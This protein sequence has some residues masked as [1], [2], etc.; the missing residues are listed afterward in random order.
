M[1]AF[2]RMKRQEPSFRRKSESRLADA[3]ERDNG[4][5]PGLRRGDEFRPGF[6]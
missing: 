3:R 2:G 4:L 5:D 1:R 6:V